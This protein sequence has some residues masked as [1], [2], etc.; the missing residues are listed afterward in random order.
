ML[1]VQSAALYL[2]W[3][4]WHWRARRISSWT[5]RFA[6]GL[7]EIELALVS[8]PAMSRSEGQTLAKATGAA[9]ATGA[10]DD[11][12]VAACCSAAAALARSIAARSAEVSITLLCSDRDF[13]A[14]PLAGQGWSEYW[15][16][17]STVHFQTWAW[18]VVMAPAKHSNAVATRRNFGMTCLP[19]PGRTHQRLPG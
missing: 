11:V 12:A 3:P 17:P 14:S 9:G 15:T 13:I 8:M 19:G 10:A 16:L 2:P 4:F 6:S 7:S 5:K 1:T 18:A